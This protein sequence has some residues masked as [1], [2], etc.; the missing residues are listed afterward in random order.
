G[1]ASAGQSSSPYIPLRDIELQPETSYLIKGLLPAKG[2]VSIYGPPGGGKTFVTLHA[3]L[4]IAAGLEFCGRRVRQT[5][6]VYFAAESGGG[7]L[8]RAALA[9]DQLGIPRDTPFIVATVAPNLGGS[10]NDIEMLLV[11]IRR[12]SERLRCA[13]GLIILDTLAR[14]IP[15]L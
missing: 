14:V 10:Q 6:V 13:P 12:E 11:E 15:G 9:R 1:A 8:N 3:A 4:H 5:G 2:L 7:F